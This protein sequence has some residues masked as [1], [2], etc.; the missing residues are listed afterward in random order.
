M[1]CAFGKVELVYAVLPEAPVKGGHGASPQYASPQQKFYFFEITWS[2]PASRRCNGTT[3]KGN[4]DLEAEFQ[5][6]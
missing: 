2:A 5:K 6:T 3:A 1:V 4:R